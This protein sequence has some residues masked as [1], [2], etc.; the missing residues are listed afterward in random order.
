MV[1][2]DLY[3]SDACR[4]VLSHGIPIHGSLELGTFFH[5]N[6]PSLHNPITMKPSACLALF[7]SVA[8]A[9]PWAP[10]EEENEK[11]V[12]EITGS[13]GVSVVVGTPPVNWEEDDD[14]DDIPEVP[15]PETSLKP[16]ETAIMP[17]P[18]NSSI[19]AAPTNNTTITPPPTNSTS[20]MPPPSTGGVD[21]VSEETVFM[22]GAANGTTNYIRILNSKPVVFSSSQYRY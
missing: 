8:I 7:A 16:N 9:A 3:I 14:D 6:L 2:L 5:T 11:N 10:W 18:S 20:I 1:V 17:P 21:I 13:N 12:P 19:T 4:S 15:L 22:T